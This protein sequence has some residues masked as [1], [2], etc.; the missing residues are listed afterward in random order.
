[1]L[2]FEQR[3]VVRIGDP[4]H[5]SRARIVP[6]VVHCARYAGDGRHLE[7][8]DDSD[9]RV[10]I[11]VAGG[12]P[13]R[14]PEYRPS[15]NSGE[16]LQSVWSRKQQVAFTTPAG[17]ASVTV[18]I[19]DL[20]GRG[21]VVGRFP[22]PEGGTEDNLHWLPDGRSVLFAAAW[23]TGAGLY[24]V[25][26]AGG[27]ATPFTSDPRVLTQ[28]TWSRNGQRI[29]YLATTG[30]VVDRTICRTELMTARAD[31]TDSQLVLSHGPYGLRSPALS[32]DGT[33]IVF[34]R[35]GSPEC[36]L[37]TVAVSGR[38]VTELAPS[39]N[40]SPPAWSPDGSS[41]ADLVVD[42]TNNTFAVRLLEPTT[43]LTLRTIS[44][45]VQPSGATGISWAWSP[46]GTRIA[47]TGLGGIYVLQVS[48]PAAAQLVVPFARQPSFSPDGTQI[49]F[50]ATVVTSAVYPTS[51]RVDL[52]VANIDGSNARVLSTIPNT[53]NGSP[54][55][56]P[57]P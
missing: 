47:I 52:M 34:L 53:Y 11:P 21:G 33:R 38:P 17:D 44:T 9:R 57:S 25:P 49:A 42:P 50:E 56:Q 37:A 55:W 45:T 18:Q 2:A 28:P 29:A 3:G 15:I 20:R 39:P 19:R 24:S 23:R 46:D 13:V 30:C 22:F 26:S 7:A 27:A 10:L 36:S 12:K 8:A 31:G 48:P 1:M 40:C 41:I 32:P 43:G 5:I 6:G 51:S 4:R 16:V 54:A 14:S 35:G